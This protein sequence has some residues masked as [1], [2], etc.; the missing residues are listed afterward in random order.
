MSCIAWGMTNVEFRW[1][2]W[3]PLALAELRAAGPEVM[4]DA[5]A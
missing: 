3:T 1:E 2:S 5:A 4:I